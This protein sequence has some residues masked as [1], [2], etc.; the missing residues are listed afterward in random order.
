MHR[1]RPLRIA[2]FRWT[3]DQMWTNHA[4]RGQRRSA[5][6]TFAVRQ[7][8]PAGPDKRFPPD[9]RLREAPTGS[10]LGHPGRHGRAPPIAPQVEPSSGGCVNDHPGDPWCCA[11]RDGNNFVSCPRLR[12]SLELPAVG[13]FAGPEGRA[14][15]ARGDRSSSSV[16]GAS[17]T[18]CSAESTAPSVSGALPCVGHSSASPSHWCSVGRCGTCNSWCRGF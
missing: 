9:C 16:A 14:R 8:P 11:W 7:S 6:R 2:W 4:R 3:V 10:G 17:A 12:P 5:S 13:W 18:S 1:W 15:G